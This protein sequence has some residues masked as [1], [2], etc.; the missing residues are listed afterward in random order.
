MLNMSARKREENKPK[1][2]SHAK[3]KHISLSLKNK[4]PDNDEVLNQTHFA[5]PI[6]SDKLEKAAEGVIPQNTHNSTK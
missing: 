3:K 6:K 2:D 5:S 4:Q 1:S